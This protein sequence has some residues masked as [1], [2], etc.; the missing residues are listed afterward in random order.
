MNYGYFSTPFPDENPRTLSNRVND[1]YFNTD[2]VSRGKLKNATT[3]FCLALGMILCIFSCAIYMYVGNQNLHN[4]EEATRQLAVTIKE[5][6]KSLTELSKN[7]N[8]MNH[9]NV[10]IPR[11]L[12]RGETFMVDNVMD[13]LNGKFF[14]DSMRK[15]KSFRNNIINKSAL[16]KPNRYMLFLIVIL[17]CFGMSIYAARRQKKGVNIIS[18]IV[19]VLLGS[20]AL[21]NMGNIISD[22][23]M[24]QE[25][26]AYF[27]HKDPRKAEASQAVI[28]KDESHM[29]TFGMTE[30]LHCFDLKFQERIREQ[31]V[32]INTGQ[33]ALYKSCVFDIKEANAKMQKP[34]AG[35]AIENPISIPTN[36]KGLIDL[37]KDIEN[38]PDDL[39]YCIRHRNLI[40]KLQEWKKTVIKIPD[41]NNYGTFYSA[42]RRLYCYEGLP[43]GI[44][45]FYASFVLFIGCLFLLGAYFRNEIM[46]KF[47]RDRKMQG[48]SQNGRRYQNYS[49][50]HLVK[51]TEM[52]TRSYKKEEHLCKEH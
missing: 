13:N 50:T 51:S 16:N 42:A 12:H 32:N 28:G 45:M 52:D 49:L 11:A 17:F 7:I 19:M 48:A 36:V 37:K 9:R 27:I 21:V 44:I 20:T 41:C 46:I 39:Y 18:C 29:A 25:I 3:S 47:T 22:E 40:E 5:S 43:N 26:C 8:T 24:F 30:Y 38:Q 23:Y 31:I 34:D 35:Q 33:L 15:A 2:H 10:V 4:F 14:K 1:R 6:R